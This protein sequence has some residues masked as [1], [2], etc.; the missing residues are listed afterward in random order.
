MHRS[1]DA[2]VDIHHG[3]TTLT[4]SKLVEAVKLLE[5]T[6]IQVRTGHRGYVDLYV[7]LKDVSPIFEQISAETFH[8]IDSEFTAVVY[9]EHQ[10]Y[11]DGT[12]VATVFS[13]NP[14][15][16]VKVGYQ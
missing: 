5:S 2:K 4:R 7:S 6:E 1:K 13:T 3:N 10:E 16:S 11:V 12:M 9:L 14:R 8:A 15:R